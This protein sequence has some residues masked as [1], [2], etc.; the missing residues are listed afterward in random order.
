MFPTPFQGAKYMCLDIKIFYLTAP[1]D[2][3]EYTKLLLSLFPSWTKE[4]Y[5]LDTLAKNEFVYLEIRR[6]VWGLSQPGILANKFSSEN[7]SYPIDITS[8]NI[9]QAY[10]NILP[11]LYPSHW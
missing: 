3:Y 9:H 10:G 6:A 2:R 1:L 8:V 7:V 5:N 4:Q 11:I